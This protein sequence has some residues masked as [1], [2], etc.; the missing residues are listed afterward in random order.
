[1]AARQNAN[2]ASMTRRSLNTALKHQSKSDASEQ[3]E[4]PRS[5]CCGTHARSGIATDARIGSSPDSVC[6]GLGGGSLVLV[7][8]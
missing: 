8:R 7:R 3:Q 1:M 4:S 2:T 6:D 5:V